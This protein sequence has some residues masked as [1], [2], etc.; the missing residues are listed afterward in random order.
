[1]KKKQEQIIDI[2]KY[3]NFMIVFYDESKHYN[4]DD[5]LFN[6]HSFKYYA[7][8]KHQPEADEKSFHYHAFIRVDNDNHHE[9]FLHI[10]LYQKEYQVY[11]L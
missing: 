8:I 4:F 9:H 10:E 11:L 7:Y 5:V 1:M 3:R 6:L 2:K